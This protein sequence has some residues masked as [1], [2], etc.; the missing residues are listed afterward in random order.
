[1]R[2]SPLVLETLLPH[3]SCVTSVLRRMSLD[4][5]SALIVISLL[6]SSGPNTLLTLSLAFVA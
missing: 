1:M 6:H 4:I 2:K 3:G 5:I